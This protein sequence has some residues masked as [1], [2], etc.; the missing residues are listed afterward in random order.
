MDGLQSILMPPLDQAPG[1]R[2]VVW[3]LLLALVGS[4]F[5][6]SRLARRDS[7][8]FLIY[9]GALSGAFIGAKLVYLF[10]EGWWDIGHADMWVRFATG[11]SIIG[12][13]LGGYGGVELVKWSI[14][15]RQATGDFFAVLAP[16]G[17]AVGRVGCWVNGCCAGSLCMQSSWWTMHDK[18]GQPRWPAV[19]VELGFNLLFA[20]TAAWLRRKG[21]LQ[22]QLFHVYLI[23]YGSFRFLHEWLRD[24]PRFFDLVSGYQLAAL[25]LVVLGLIHFKNRRGASR[26]QI[27]NSILH[28]TR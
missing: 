12:G 23:A 14:G 27:P 10:A 5:F 22:G 4:V 26:K 28:S 7:R 1:S 21:R 9:L 16:L 15:Y 17:I 13:L 18:Q 19:P 20:L 2:P 25:A 6:W 11:K 3:F 8:L 24:T